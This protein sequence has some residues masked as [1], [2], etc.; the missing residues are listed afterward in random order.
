MGCPPT[1]M[2]FHPLKGTITLLSSVLRIALLPASLHLA[3]GRSR[4][5]FLLWTPSTKACKY[6]ALCMHPFLPIDDSCRFFKAANPS[7]IERHIYVIPIPTSASVGT[8]KPKPLTNIAVSAYHDANFS[9]QGGYYLLSYDGPS[10][11]YQNIL[12]P[13]NSSKQRA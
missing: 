7:S 2:L 10:A 11:P 5:P 12:Q 6:S 1:W 13:G 3:S 9:P 8:E 4:A